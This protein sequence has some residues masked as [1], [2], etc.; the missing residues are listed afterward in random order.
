MKIV[1]E[2]SDDHMRFVRQQAGLHGPAVRLDFENFVALIPGTVTGTLGEHGRFVDKGDH[3]LYRI[4]PL[5][6]Q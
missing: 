6:A 2:I 5:E 3:P 4:E 1:I